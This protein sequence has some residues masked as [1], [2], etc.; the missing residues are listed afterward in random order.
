MV[1][2]S[3]RFYAIMS[4]GGDIMPLKYN[5]DVLQALKEK[6]YSAYKLA[7]DKLLS[8]SS[9]QKLRKGEPL[10]ADGIATLCELLNC[11]PGDIIRYEEPEE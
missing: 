7:Q 3:I 9:I 8:G 4:A 5:F 10:G 11:Q 6:G 2:I 1:F